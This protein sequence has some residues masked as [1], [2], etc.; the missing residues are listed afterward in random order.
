VDFAGLKGR[1]LSSSYTP[2]SG[3]PHH[4]SMIAELSEIYRAHQVNGL[5]TFEYITRMYYGQLAC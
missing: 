1:M 3:H 5:V 4:E 2:E